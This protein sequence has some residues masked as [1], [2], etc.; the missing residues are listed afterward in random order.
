MN[1]P[2]PATVRKYVAAVAL[3]GMAAYAFLT[4]LFVGRI[5][6]V[7]RMFWLFAPMLFLTELLTIKVPRNSEEDEIATSTSFAFA[8]LLVAGLA[9]TVVV[10]GLACAFADVVRGKPLWKVS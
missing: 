5:E 1:T 7:P 10:Q 3:P 2:D 9:P 6:S 8:S 4:Y